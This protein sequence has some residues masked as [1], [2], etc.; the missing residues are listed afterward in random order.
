LWQFTGEDEI[1][2]S[3]SVAG[4]SVFVGDKSGHLYA[5]DALTGEM[6]WQFKADG[7]ISSTPVV[8]NG[9]VYIASLDGTLYAI[10]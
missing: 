9:T 5:V 3:P 10:E 1:T 6:Q 8:A 4:Q 7:P 2:T